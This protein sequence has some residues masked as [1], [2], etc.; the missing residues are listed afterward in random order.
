MSGHGQSYRAAALAAIGGFLFGYDI[1][2][3]GSAM[4]MDNFKSYFDK[5]DAFM[6][7]FIVAMLTLGCF[8]GSLIAAP[9]TDRLSRKR[10]IMIAAFVFTVGGALQCAAWARW[11]LILGR[12]IAGLGIGVLS[13]AVPLFQSEIAP[14]QLRGRLISFQQLSI[15]IGIAVSFWIDYGFLHLGDTTASWRVPLGLQIAPALLL[16]FG[17]TSMPESPRWLVD[18]DRDDEAIAVLAKLRANGDKTDAAVL[19]EYQE[20]KDA[21]MFDR[22]TALRSYR[23]LFRPVLRRRTWL[24]I[25][26]QAM[27]QLTGINVI[28][29]YAPY[30]FLQAGLGSV[31]STLLAQ[32]INGVVNMG[33]TIPAILYVD[34]WGRRPTLLSGSL[35]MGLAYL[36]IG[37]VMGAT[38]T[39]V[40]LD[41]GTAA[42]NISSEAA[43][44]TC[45]VFVYVFVGGFAYSWGPV[46]WIYPAEI[47]PLRVRSK[48]TSFTTASNWLFN[49][50][51]AQVAPIVMQAITWKFYLI[52]M[53]FNW[54][55]LLVV[56]YFYPET[57][58]R[59]L[60]EMDKVFGAPSA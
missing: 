10:S 12:V 49:F 21:V 35:I 50:V 60:E 28:M 24:G 44:Y 15:T 18:N 26:I 48:A 52:F 32:G 33:M 54:L 46:G 53:A 7:G 20:I 34:R 51:I 27:Q 22:R 1:G 55:S 58:G 23:E 3:M 2:V 38:G 39:P 40:T 29:Y 45:I 11:V 56:W 25:G 36:V 6:R 30:I 17:I 42:M 43:K 9:M 14:K 16:G 47:Y 59:S 37:A 8:L 31:S 41:D 5:P 13:M 57:K 19:A 4:A